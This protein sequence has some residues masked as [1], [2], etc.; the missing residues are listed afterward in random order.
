[1]YSIELVAQVGERGLAALNI[2][3]VQHVALTFDEFRGRRHRKK[4]QCRIDKESMVI[5]GPPPF[6]FLPTG[7]QKYARDFKTQAGELNRS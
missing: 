2:G 4:C 7:D 3:S 1:M 5:V 6:L